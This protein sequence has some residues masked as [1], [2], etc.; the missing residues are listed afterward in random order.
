M[1]EQK[2]V[3]CK[4]SHEIYFLLYFLSIPVHL[5]STQKD[6]LIEK[7]VFTY[8]IHVVKCPCTSAFETGSRALLVPQNLKLR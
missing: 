5:S 1:A 2:A 8:Q 7:E 3:D 6:F 4:S